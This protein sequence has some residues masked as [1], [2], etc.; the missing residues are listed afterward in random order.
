MLVWDGFHAKCIFAQQV[1]VGA[2]V[3]CGLFALVVWDGVSAKCIFAQQAQ[4]GASV[5]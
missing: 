2:S 5:R 1:Q 4:V 3:R